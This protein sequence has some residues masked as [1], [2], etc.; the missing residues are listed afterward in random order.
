MLDFMCLGN[1]NLSSG[2]QCS[3]MFIT[4][5]IIMLFQVGTCGSVVNCVLLSKGLGF[6]THIF[7]LKKSQVAGLGKKL[8][9]GFHFQ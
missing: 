4:M 7:R 8:R 1:I 6:N 9:W 2:S 3:W 5:S